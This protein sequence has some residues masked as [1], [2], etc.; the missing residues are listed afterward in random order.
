ME[1]QNNHETRS[2]SGET[3]LKGEKCIVSSSLEE[4]H[5][6]YE[7]VALF[8]STVSVTKA[9]SPGFPWLQYSLEKWKEL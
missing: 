6:Q 1:G 3:D 2:F 9:D 8:F 7:S 5:L 4:H